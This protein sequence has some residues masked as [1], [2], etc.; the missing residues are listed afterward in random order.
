[1]V[2]TSV[3]TKSKARDRIREPEKHQL[4]GGGFRKSEMK[5][6]GKG[7]SKRK[8]SD[9][10]KKSLVDEAQRTICELASVCRKGK[11]KIWGKKAERERNKSPRTKEFLGRS[12]RWLFLLLILMQ[13]WF[14][15]DAA[16]GRLEPKGEA[17]VPEIIIVSDAVEGTFVNLDGKSFQEEHKGKYQREWKRSKGVDRKEM[18]KEEKNLR[19]AFEN[20]SAWSTER[21]YMRRYE[22]TFDV[23]LGIEHRLRKEEMEEQFNREAK[24]G[25]R[26]ATSAARITYRMA[27]DDDRKHTSVLKRT[28]TAKHPWL[29]ACDA[30]M[31]PEDFEK[32]P[33][34]SKRAN[35]RDGTRRSVKVQIKKC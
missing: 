28:R 27:G 11:E 21:K 20:G 33:L 1:M 18:R 10:Q 23:F 16:A 7:R 8:T 31:G 32:K 30:N 17:E 13:S 6:S 3:L 34:V 5:R 22:G 14:C 26:F 4:K 15:V 19:C 9:A 35:V 24:E 2:G 25:W 29:I 12:G